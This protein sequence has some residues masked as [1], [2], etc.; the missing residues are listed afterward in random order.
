MGSFVLTSGVLE[1]TSR[2]LAGMFE[3]AFSYRSATPLP[4]AVSL[5]DALN[6]LHDFDTVNRLNPDVR[7]SRPIVPKPGKTNSLPPPVPDAA[8]LDGVAL[9]KVQYFEVED[10][11]PFIPKKM[12][13][14]GVKYQADFVPM[15][16]GCDITI[17]APG[18]FI[19]VNH[20]RLVLDETKTDAAPQENGMRADGSAMPPPLS[21]TK[22]KDLMHTESE[23]VGWYVQIVSDARCNRTFAS[24]VRGFLKNSHAQLQQAFIS[25][26]ETMRAALSDAD[27]GQG[28]R[29]TLNRRRSSM[30]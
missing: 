11:L 13:S 25:K 19:S 7:G 18:G 24:F 28:R 15:E 30:F 29:P 27:Q 26:L 6:V 3:T 2:P 22:S 8:P 14:G 9:G 20:W 4:P 1:K 23:G 16:R 17:H 12:W 10:D 21:R 5:T